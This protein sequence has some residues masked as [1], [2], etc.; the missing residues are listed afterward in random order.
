MSHYIRKHEPGD[1]VP[2]GWSLV[3]MPEEGTFQVDN[4]LAAE[5]NALLKS[6]K[7]DKARTLFSWLDTRESAS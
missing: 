5:L 2:R 6:G 1:V 4:T 7:V 3:T